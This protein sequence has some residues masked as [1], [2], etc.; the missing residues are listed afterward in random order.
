[1][2]LKAVQTIELITNATKRI[3]WACYFILPEAINIVQ[4]IKK[5]LYPIKHE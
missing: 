1:M 4:I 3:S 5:N 2:K